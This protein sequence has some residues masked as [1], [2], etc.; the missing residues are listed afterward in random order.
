LHTHLLLVVEDAVEIC[1]AG[2]LVRLVLRAARAFAYTRKK[3]PN[4]TTV[5]KAS[6]G[7]CV[8]RANLIASPIKNHTAVV[9]QADGGV[10]RIACGHAL[11]LL[12]FTGW[13]VHTVRRV[14]NF[15][16]DAVALERV[17]TPVAL[18][19][20][21]HSD[22]RC[23]RDVAGKVLAAATAGTTRIR[24]RIAAALCAVDPVA[25]DTPR[26]HILISFQTAVGL[27]CTVRKVPHTADVCVALT[28]V[29]IAPLAVGNTPSSAPCALGVGLAASLQS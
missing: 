16:A 20:A 18:I 4:A 27:A 10:S 1:L 11:S 5:L 24:I 14:R 15:C 9:S 12:I 28:L 19:A 13:V 6:A 22:A 8:I 3:V 17:W 26:A 23:V 7:V 29:P 21:I 2:C 25:H